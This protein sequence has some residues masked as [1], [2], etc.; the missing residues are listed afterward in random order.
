MAAKK[1]KK[2]NK[3]KEVN[4]VHWSVNVQAYE[5]DIPAGK[6]TV[7]DYDHDDREIFWTRGTFQ[8]AAHTSEYKAAEEALDKYLKN[9]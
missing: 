6:F 8:L 4:C 3:T 2:K 9:S 5:L 7:V 1:T